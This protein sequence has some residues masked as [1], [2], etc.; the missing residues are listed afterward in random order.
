M[1][2]LGKSWKVP[3]RKR[4]SASWKQAPIRHAQAKF[5]YY[6]LK[7]VNRKT[8]KNYSA[9]LERF[10]GMFPKLS[11]PE[12]FDRVHVEDFKLIRQR[13][14]YS[15]NGINRDLQVVDQFW[16]YMVDHELAPRNVA[17]NVRVTKWVKKEN[18]RISLN[19]LIRLA[20][21][22]HDPRVAQFAKNL[23]MGSTPTKAAAEAGMSYMMAWKGLRSAFLRCNLEGVS[24]QSLRKISIPV[25]L[26][27]LVES[28]DF[29]E[30]NT[31]VVESELES[32]TFTDIQVSA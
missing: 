20:R 3:S 4:P 18:R 17:A 28:L 29:K 10:L 26:Q 6:T 5:E 7:S 14:G 1:S 19:D 11:K 16:Q 31:L 25:A 30:S 21:E 24:P 2:T 9:S 32:D 8:C 22:L 27:F 13:N 15:N 23:L 12:Q